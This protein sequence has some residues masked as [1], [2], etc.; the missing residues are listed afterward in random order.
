MRV[1]DAE[2][3]IEGF[4]EEV[5]RDP[6]RIR[7]RQ[8]LSRGSGAMVHNICTG[9]IRP[10]MYNGYPTYGYA[11]PLTAALAWPVSSAP[12]EAFGERGSAKAEM[13]SGADGKVDEGWMD[14]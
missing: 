4:G 12:V 3:A 5:V 10:I 1:G 14:G 7:G 11:I 2:E 13:G 6:D 8:R 9:D